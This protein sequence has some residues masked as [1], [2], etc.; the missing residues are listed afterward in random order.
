MERVDSIVETRLLI[1]IG[2]IVVF[3]VAASFP[4]AKSSQKRDKI[5]GGTAARSFHYLGVLS[6]LVVLP[7]ALI[8]SILIGPLEF[9]IPVA[10]AALLVSIVCLMLYAVFEQPARAAL[11]SEDHG[12][13]EKD[14]R[15]SGL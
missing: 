3:A 2:I 4:V 15:T 13:T 14:A 8:G 9:G 10:V 5:Y 11:P 7:S 6:Y 12:W 1:T